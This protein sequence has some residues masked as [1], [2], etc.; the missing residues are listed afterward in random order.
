M[1]ELHNPFS[2]LP[3]FHTQLFE[4]KILQEPDLRPGDIILC[5]CSQ[6]RTEVGKENGY[7]HAAMCYKDGVVIE[8]DGKLVRDT[9][10][11]ALLGQYEHLAIL[12]AP[13]TWSAERLFRLKEFAKERLGA[14]F[15]REGL[16]NYA[17]NRAESHATAPERIQR[18]FDGLEK[19]APAIK[20]DYFCS[21]LVVA[22]FN[23][24]GIVDESA[25]VIMRPEI[26]LPEDIAKDKA[27]GFFVGYI[28]PY[29]TY[30]IPSN[31][32]FRTNL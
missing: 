20:D 2:N 32:F 7:S 19:P 14:K 30:A 29:D 15:N 10:L 11:A 18:Y 9:T 27:F 16:N 1:D 24:V 6:Y 28:L 12:R 17:S 26:F 25:A 31:D 3:M 22:A 13:D 4:P 21:E 23:H 5:Y 8:A